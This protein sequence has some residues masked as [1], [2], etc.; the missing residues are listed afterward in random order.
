MRHIFSSLGDICTNVREG[1]F[2]GSRATMLK[3]TEVVFVEPKRRDVVRVQLPTP[4]ACTDINPAMQVYAIVEIKPD[5][6][7]GPVVMRGTFDVAGF[8]A[9]T[10]VR[11]IHTSVGATAGDIV[12]VTR[13]SLHKSA[14]AALSA[15]RNTSSATSDHGAVL[16]NA[17]TKRRA[18]AGGMFSGTVVT[19]AATT[20][21]LTP[22][23]Q[24]VGG[25]GWGGGGGGQ[26]MDNMFDC[27]FK[28]ICPMAQ[29]STPLPRRAPVEIAAPEPLVADLTLASVW[30]GV[31][32]W[33]SPTQTAVPPIVSV[34]CGV[35]GGPC[36]T[37]MPPTDIMGMMQPYMETLLDLATLSR[38]VCRERAHGGLLHASGVP[39]TD[40]E[41]K[42]RSRWCPGASSVSSWGEGGCVSMCDDV[43]FNLMGL[44]WYEQEALLALVVVSRDGGT[45]GDHG[46][47][48]TYTETPDRTSRR[49]TELNVF[50]R[51][52]ACAL[53]LRVIRGTARV[54]GKCRSSPELLTARVWDLAD[55]WGGCAV[56]RGAPHAFGMPPDVPGGGAALV[57]AAG[58]RRRISPGSL[59]IVVPSCLDV[60]GGHWLCWRS[61]AEG[62]L[63]AVCRHGEGLGGAGWGCCTDCSIE[64]GGG[65]SGCI[66]TPE[67]VMSILRYAVER[68]HAVRVEECDST[69]GG[70][71]WWVRAS[72]WVCVC[73][74]WL[75]EFGQWRSQ[76]TTP[77]FARVGR[78][79][80]E[81]LRS[82]RSQLTDT[83]LSRQWEDVVAL[84]SS[85]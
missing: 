36:I 85:G 29:V 3:F 40:A 57:V 37:D 71:I 59:P 58:T 52:S 2:S 68:N 54:F 53:E 4:L 69:S 67:V 82:S 43:L 19:T 44:G 72:N 28:D 8:V 81:H 62:P 20:N 64:G 84:V 83:K 35:G 23:R 70:C 55:M 34:L 9:A 65:N 7:C 21:M 51:L 74:A 56:G 38:L 24:R 77:G 15:S 31:R 10:S 22:K 41:S 75:C 14:Y 27:M 16:V 79:V 49:E 61:S 45:C 73:A 32:S 12:M 11:H 13:A 25:G 66:Q 1:Y 33:Q 63:D 18:N 76:M 46:D 17:P 78:I 26:D 42:W 6:T 39:I 48:S 30:A 80:H 47:R 5:A 50:H 60:V